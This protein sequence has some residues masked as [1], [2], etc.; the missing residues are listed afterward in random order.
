MEKLVIYHTN[1]DF[2]AC[3]WKHYPQVA[4]KQF[5]F[6]ILKVEDNEEQEDDQNFH[7]FLQLENDLSS[8]W[9]T[10][11][12]FPHTPHT[13]T[14]WYTWHTYICQL[15]DSKNFERRFVKSSTLVLLKTSFLRQWNPVKFDP[16][17]QETRCATISHK[18]IVANCEPLVALQ[19]DQTLL[20]PTCSLFLFPVHTRRHLGNKFIPFP[21]SSILTGNP[22][23]E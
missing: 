4:D 5:E 13:S 11:R 3:M 10:C 15:F 14:S 17:F 16:N 19:G 7:L 12:S 22:I 23:A 20:W 1:Q 6:G 9:P 18:K 21:V 2:M 8:P